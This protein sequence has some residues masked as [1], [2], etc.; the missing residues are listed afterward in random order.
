METPIIAAVISGIVAI[1]SPIITYLITRIYDRRGLG[2]IL[3]RRKALIGIWKGSIVQD[4]D[5]ELGA[6]SIDMSFTSSGKVVEGNFEFVDPISNQVIKLKFTGGFY[7]EQF[8]KF[9]YTNAD[10]LVVQFGS[11]IMSLASDG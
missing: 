11:A 2:R 4:N 1:V 8:A 5:R 6:I 10:E 7:H 9:D 3:G